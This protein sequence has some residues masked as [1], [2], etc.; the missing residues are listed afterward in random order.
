[1]CDFDGPDGLR[2]GNAIVSCHMDADIMNSVTVMCPRQVDGTEYVWHPQPNVEEQG[3]LKTY[4]SDDGAFSSVSISRVVHFESMN[5]FF[6]MQ[7]TPSQTSMHVKLPKDELVVITQR[8]LIFICGPKDL[9]LTD[10][11]QR[12]LHVL[13]ELGQMESVPWIPTTPLTEE[14]LEIGK[15]LGVLLLTRDRRYLPLQGCGSRPSLL[16]APNNVMV[17]SKTGIR[18]CVADPIS[19]SLIGFVCEGRLEPNDCMKSLLDDDGAVV[20]AP[21][22]HAYLNFQNY[23]H[24]IVS[25][26]FGEVATRPFSGECR[27]IDPETGHVKARIEIRQKTDHV[28]DIASMIEGNKS[29]PKRGPWCSVVLHPGSTLTIKVPTQPSNPGSID[30][31]YAEGYGSDVGS[32]FHALPLSHL[33]SIYD[34]ETG[35]MPKNLTT[36]RQQTDFYDLEAY[37]ELSYDEALAGDA[38]ELD[39]SQ[40]DRGEVKLKYHV[41]KP[42]TLRNGQNSFMFHWTSQPGNY[43]YTDTTRATVNVAFAFTHDYEMVGCDR[44]TPSVFDQYASRKYC[45]TKRMGNGIEDTY[46]CS[47]NVVSDNKPAGIYC[48]PDEELLPNNCDSTGYDLYSNKI[49]T[50]HG[51]VENTTPYPITGFQAL[52]FHALHDSPVSY[53]CFCVDQRGYEKSRLVMSHNMLKSYF[54][55]TEHINNVQMQRQISD[56][57]IFSSRRSNE[58]R[59]PLRSLIAEYI[60]KKSVVLNLGTH[61]TMTCNPGLVY[62]DFENEPIV[63]SI[64][65]P[66]QPDMYYYSVNRTARGLQLI[67]N[68]YSDSIA[69]TPG[70]YSISFKPKLHKWR[71]IF[72]I[73]TFRDS[74]LVSKDP[75]HRKYVSMIFVCGKE[76]EQPHSSILTGNSYSYQRLRSL[77][78]SSLYTWNVVEVN[79]ETTDPY[80]QGCGVTYESDELFKPETPK[81]Y[82]ADGQPQ[83]GCKI[84][85]QAAKEAA[86][87]C[88]APYALDPPNCFNHVSVDG[89]LKNLSD[90]SQS[91]VDDSSNHFVILRFDSELIGPGETLRKTP[92]LECRCV[93]TKGIVLST[94]QIENYYAK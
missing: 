73:Q 31:E 47:V 90:I 38:L 30:K 70:G 59:M 36:L 1:M 80:M 27:C 5:K 8:R 77:L 40:L 3:H 78:Y 61:L 10:T 18:S 76:L 56:A 53:A 88:P 51:S 35:F 28:C 66:R 21:K 50:M 19:P 33:P 62:R 86:F 26:Y 69:S 32:G 48:Q 85:I 74:V 63:P 46:E 25:R 44:S 12:H 2:S 14:M 65:W 83:F 67:R 24:W 41:D 92:P 15:S 58:E 81:L 49:V 42:L 60:T 52:Y 22:P 45:S 11:L 7:T 94:I 20:A 68:R 39:V 84:D 87:Y 34:Y 75:K 72:T 29:H 71:E 17:D 4:V 55:T 89:E 23:G 16:F 6:W 82:D 43:Y 54:F 57:P 13:H 37:D 79:M 64:W 91:L 93:T 9:V